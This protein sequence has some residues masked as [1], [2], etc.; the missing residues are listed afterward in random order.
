MGNVRDGIILVDKN[1]GETSFEAA[2]RV[3]RILKIRKVGHAGTLDP[4]ATG[5][6]IVLLGQG[7]KLFP[8]LASGAKEY[9]GILRLGVETDTQDVHGEIL[10]VTPVPEFVPEELR[11]RARNFV[12]EIEQVPPRFS[13]VRYKGKR[14]YEYARKGIDVSLGARKVKIHSFDILSVDLPEVTVRVVC[15]GGTY[16]RALVSDF[17]KALGT[18]AH[19]TALRRLASGPFDIR[20]AVNI[21]KVSGPDQKD[22]LC[23][24]II[25]LGNGLPHLRA[26]KIGD[27]M[28]RKIRNG[29]QPKMRDLRG[30]G[31]DLGGTGQEIKLLRGEDLVAIARVPDKAHG[32]GVGLKVMRVFK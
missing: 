5:L 28:A 13:A 15:S 23:E 8:Y 27:I 12:G 14:A 10:N 26:V 25:P 32:N 17:G 7:T 11:A 20:D 30:P 16:V 24:R 1:E 22:A 29:Y 21:N 31:D 6:L 2:G 19:L 4:F 3:G 9:T 18:G